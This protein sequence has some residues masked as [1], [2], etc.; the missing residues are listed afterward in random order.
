MPV[1]EYQVKEGVKGCA[2]CREPFEEMRLLSDAPLLTCPVCGAAIVKLISAPSLGRSQ[3]KL[4]D[5][6]K[7]AGFHKLKR[8][9]KGA[10]EKLY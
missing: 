7:S 10:F 2:N 4:D 8:V 3:A 9:D 1:Y 6:A 5:R